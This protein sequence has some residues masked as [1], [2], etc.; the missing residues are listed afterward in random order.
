MKIFLSGGGS[1]E[2]SLLLDRKFAE[3]LDKTKPLLYIPIAIDKLKHPYSECFK[4]I[5]GLFN[6]LG[7]GE[8]ELWT[9]EDLAKRQESE[10]SKYSGVYIGG[11]NTFYLLSELKKSRFFNKLKKIINSGIPVYGG[12]AGAVVLGK[13]ILT[14]PDENFVKI[15]DCSG[16]DLVD[17]YS[18]ICHFDKN[19][20]ENSAENFKVRKTIA[21]PEDC[22]LYVTESQIEVVGQGSA[23]LPDK[24]I[25][26]GPGERI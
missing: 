10:I 24:D 2:K 22:G 11:G 8:I 6:P 16:M 17:G 5:K 25:T 15:K 23:Y 7:V 1:G 13:S 9:E 18:I 21:L 14:S 4:W 19:K 12:S 20:K 26:L 3:T